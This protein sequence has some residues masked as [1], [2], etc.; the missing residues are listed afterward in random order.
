MKI[1]IVGANG[2]IGSAVARALA[3]DHEIIR[4]GRTHGDVHADYTD[5]ES[6]AAMFEQIGPV[7]A[8]IA[9]VGPDGVLKPYA[10][11]TD[12]DYRFGFERKVLSQVRL[13]T[14]G[15]PHLRDNGCF[16]LSSGSLS[17]RPKPTSVATGPMDAAIDVYVQSV[18]PL[19][20]R[21]IRINIV[22]PAHVAAPGGPTPPGSI[23]A[24]AAAAAYLDALT[25]PNTGQVLRVW[26]GGPNA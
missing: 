15:T 6:V 1:I 25:S 20:P 19:R 7:D 3:A 21:G 9:T 14:L 11:L 4:V 10:D 8:C 24:D 18:A 12:D 23:T 5:A 17:D 22:S 16:V 13:V 2:C 26:N